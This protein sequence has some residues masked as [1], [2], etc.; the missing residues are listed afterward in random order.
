MGMKIGIV[1]VY[2]SLNYGAFLQAYA[3]QS[4]L[5]AQQ[6]EIYFL[7]NGARN[8]NKLFIK[9]IIK[10]ML[11]F[12]C[13]GYPFQFKMRKMFLQ[14]KR[15]FEECSFED[16]KQ[17]DCAIFG[18][19]EIWNAKRKSIYNFP[20]F[21]G[22]GVE[23]KKKIAYAPSVNQA[24]EADFLAHPE[25]IMGLKTFSGI[26]L[27]DTHSV[28]QIQSLLG[29]EELKQVVDPTLLQTPAFYDAIAVSP[30]EEAPYILLYSYGK[31]LTAEMKEQIKA[32]SKKQNMQL[33]S[34]LEHFSWCDKNIVL[35]PFEVLGYFKCAAYVITDTF[36]GSIFSMIYNRQFVVMSKNSNKIVDLM[37]SFGLTNR[38][39]EQTLDIMEKMEEAINYETVNTLI[40]ERRQESQKVLFDMMKK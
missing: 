31:F 26:A 6:H 4:L 10:K 40:E 2:S 19:D 29:W 9:K 15:E 36:H 11:K 33:I 8:T 17:M 16:M 25:L 22:V 28:K 12:Q 3:L 14:A 39:M 18:S 37:E 24:R 21:F 5:K 7:N 38:I 13:T 20:S 32:F 35:S 23:C 1:T 30:L 27:R 34:V